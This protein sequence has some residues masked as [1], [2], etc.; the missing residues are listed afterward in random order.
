MSLPRDIPCVIN[1]DNNQSLRD[2]SSIVNHKQSEI[3]VE[4]QNVAAIDCAHTDE[5][6]RNAVDRISLADGTADVDGD[7]IRLHNRP[8][9][10]QI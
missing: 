10:S 5:D 2:Q 9:T 7:R 6:G 8:K 4:S 3:S 1:C